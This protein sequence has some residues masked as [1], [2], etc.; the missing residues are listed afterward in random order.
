MQSC[1]ISLPLPCL[2]VHKFGTWPASLKAPSKHIFQLILEKHDYFRN[3][4]W[5]MARFGCKV[6]RTMTGLLGCSPQLVNVSKWVRTCYNP[7]IAGQT[8]LTPLITGVYMGILEL[9]EFW[10]VINPFIICGKPPSGIYIHFLSSNVQC[11]LKRSAAKAPEHFIHVMSFPH[12]RCQ[13]EN[14]ELG[15]MSWATAAT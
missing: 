8:P 9:L 4:D 1:W 11:H 12:L 10:H 5:I 15:W 3:W 14:G 7:V 13:E 2:G 6:D